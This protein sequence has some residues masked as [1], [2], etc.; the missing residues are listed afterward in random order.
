MQHRWLFSI[1]LLALFFV[2]GCAKPFKL[3]PRGERTAEIGLL[4]RRQYCANPRRRR[5]FRHIDTLLADGSIVGFNTAGPCNAL[6]RAFVGTDG[7]VRRND[8]MVGDQAHNADIEAARNF[9]FEGV[10]M[11]FVT[12]WVRIPVTPRQADA[13]AEAWV[14]MEKDPPFF[15]LLN[16]NCATRAA[17]ALVQAGIIPRGIPSIETPGNLMREMKRIYGDDLRFEE[18]FF[19]YVDGQP[20]LDPFPIMD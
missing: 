10:L 11:P 13:L 20:T 3:P 12:L 6:I 14:E 7:A 4:L 18:G 19:G 2:S 17:Q 5:M 15:R 16:R 9:H 1:L 8:W